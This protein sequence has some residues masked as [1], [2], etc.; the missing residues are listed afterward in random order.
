MLKTVSLIE[1]AFAEPGTGF[2][3]REK[4]L[5]R[6]LTDDRRNLLEHVSISVF[7]QTDL[8]VRTLLL[9]QPNAAFS[10]D[11]RLPEEF[12]VIKPENFDE[13]R[14]AAWCD[15]LRGLEGAYNSFKH[16]VYRP[17]FVRSILPQCFAARLVMTA[18]VREWRRILKLM[19]ADETSLQ[20][21]ALLKLLHAQLRCRYVILFE[22]IDGSEPEPPNEGP[23]ITRRGNYVTVSFGDSPNSQ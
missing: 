6:I 13:E 1:Q 3:T 19:R 18:S 20:L 8:A 15:T 21:K 12:S 2:E 10:I 16:A 5:K 11:L 17:E 22:D 23:S 7:F 14:T 4:L 9:Q